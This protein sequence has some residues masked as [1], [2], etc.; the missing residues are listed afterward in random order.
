MSIIREFARFIEP[1]GELEYDNTVLNNLSASTIQS[2]IDE[3]SVLV[4]A[5]NVGSQATFSVYE[6][7]ATASQ[8]TFDLAGTFTLGGDITAGNFVI[9]E[10]YKIQ[11]LGDTDWN[12]AAGTT[13]VTYNV[14]DVFTAADVGSGTGVVRV[15]VTYPPG[16]IQ[17]FVNGIFMAAVDYTA[18]NGRT[19]VLA[20]PAELSDLITVVILDSF[21]VA[22][23]L[24]V[25]DVNAS[26]PDNSLA[27][28]NV[29]DVSVVSDIKLADNGKVIFGDSGDLEIYHSGSDSFITDNGTGD[30]KISGEAQIKL[31]NVAGQFYATFNNNL[32]VNL[33]Y[34]N[35]QKFATTSTGINV[36]GTVTADGLTVDGAADGT[37]IAL[38][39]ADNTAFTKK[40]T[41]RFEDT[42]TTTQ[43]DQQIGRI[44]FY[45]N[46]TDHTGVDA[47]IEAVSATTGLKELR[48]LTSDTANTPLSRLAINRLGDISFYEDTGTTPKLFWDAS[49]ESLGIGTQSPAEELHIYKAAT[50][51]RIRISHGTNTVSGFNLGYSGQDVVITN[52]ENGVMLF[53]TNN[54]ER[55]RID[56]NGNLLV[57]VITNSTTTSA[58][59]LVYNKGG[60]LLVTR[61]QA[62]QLYLTRTSTNGTMMIF[63]RDTV[64]VGQINSVGG[65]DIAIGTGDTGLRFYNTEK[66]I[67]PFDIDSG[68]NSDDSIS[69]GASNK[70]FT[71][72]FLSG[73]VVFGATGGA[74]TSKTLGDYEEG[75]FTLTVTSSG[76]TISAQENRYTKIGNR[77][78]L[79]GSVTFSAIG[80]NNSQV[81]FSG[82]PLAED[83]TEDAV[84][85]VARENTT[86]GDIF[87]ALL[88]GATF[89]M[90]SMDGISGGSN[91]IFLTSKKYGY[92]IN[93]TT[94]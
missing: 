90:N 50:D 54:I 12:V 81:T 1:T 65:S 89:I 17:V 22:T 40:N 59:G 47:V 18:S 75:T 66:R 49:A 41:L 13:G 11:T 73:G 57:G 70:R 53:G 8:T 77:V 28:D 94:A 43:N 52:T 16:Y 51:P 56:E 92:S 68:L 5:G 86:S 67:Q 84:V 27:I 2:A 62:P 7:V 29:G 20:E 36:T 4:G 87:S 32:G 71:D 25:L 88:S 58:E 69:L 76:Y 14:G 78:F 6:F 3:L 46:D 34:N 15:A 19:V 37:A 39:R 48:F 79:T 63:R 82:V 35:G 61:D 74:V 45:S 26:A 42:D 24:R 64:E 80:T 10:T 91:Q 60:S 33:Y 55:M 30:L 83:F 85:G 9:G 44:E 38:L 93:Y 72:L 23:Q 21:D 31:G